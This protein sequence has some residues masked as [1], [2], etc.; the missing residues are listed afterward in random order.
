LSYQGYAKA[1]PVSDYQAQRR[2]GR[3][4]SATKTKDED[5]VDKLFVA[6]THD[7]L[8]CFSSLGKVY[9]L[10]VYEL[11][12]ASRGSRGKPIVNL[13]PLDA[14][15]CIDAVL[16]VRD[17]D[18]EHFIFMATSNGTVKKTKLTAFARPRTTGLKAIELRDDNTLVDV[19]VT[20]GSQDIMLFASSGKAIRFPEE[21]VRPMGRTAAGVR[22]IR[23]KEGQE[24]I[25]LIVVE[26]EGAILLACANGYGKRTKASEFMAKN[27]GGQGMIAIKATERNGNL[28]G[29]VQVKEADGCMI[30]TANGTL[31]RTKVAGIS[32]VGRNTQGVRLIRVDEGDALVGLEKIEAAE[33]ED[34]EVVT[35]ENSDDSEE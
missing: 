18:D 19:A 15:E 30:I 16:P 4:K 29:A 12:I 14:D 13:L 31:I 23:L 6:S 7:N 26:E 2:G 22:G 32:V 25:S 27:R 5:Y 28:V 8:L 20:N 34:D 3:G 24:I 35:L 21:K 17:F 11:P 33:I 9:T 1:Q 10:K